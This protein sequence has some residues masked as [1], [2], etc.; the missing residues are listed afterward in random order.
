MITTPTLPLNSD[1]EMSLR[2]KSGFVNVGGKNA[3]CVSGKIEFQE[4]EEP[5]CLR[6]S[7][8]LLNLHHFLL[9][10]IFYFEFD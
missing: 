2:C 10:L 3:T 9:H 6:A 8:S 7:K 4:R 5:S 1:T